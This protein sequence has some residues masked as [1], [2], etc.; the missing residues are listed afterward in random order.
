MGGAQRSAGGFIWALVDETV[1][2]D[3]RGGA[4]DTNGN[5]APDGIVGPFREKEGSFYTI[6]D[7]W[8]PIQLS[9]PDYYASTFPASYD[10]TTKIQNRYTFTNVNRLTFAWQ[11]VTFPGPGAGTGHTVTAQGSFPGPDVAPGANGVLVLGLPTNWRDADALRLAATDAAGRLVTSFM[12]RIKKAADYRARLVAPTS[13]SVTAAETSSGVTMTAGATSITISKSNGRLS[14][15]NRNGTTVSLTNGPALAAG[16]ASFTGLSHFRDGTGWVVQADYTGDLS[17]VRWRLDANGWLQM[18]YRYHRT[19]NHD[20]LGVNLDY[21]EANVRSVTWLGDGPHRVYKNR[22]RGVSSDVWSKAYNN[23]ATGASG[24]QYP[25][26]KGYHARTCWARLSTSEGTITIVAAEDG[27]YLR[28]FTP[29]TGPD[30]QTATVPYPAGGIS[31][32]D[33]IPAIGNK[34][35]GAA[36]LGPE[37]QPV[38][39]AGDYHRSVY[40]Q[41]GS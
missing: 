26:F 14:G 31:L 28:L 25:E 11:L 39:A 40:F 17:S 35:H 33:G 37:S 23:A 29:A 4:L 5:R 9:S 41:F 15:V 21:P 19:G 3:D 24:F 34:F 1:V 30:P 13:G 7:I 27:L 20:Y 22:L 10:G 16:T 12:W 8:S 32:L 18:E 36:A 6:K 2:R 38:V